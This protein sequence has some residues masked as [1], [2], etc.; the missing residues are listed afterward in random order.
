MVI[1]FPRKNLY[2]KKLR[3]DSLHRRLCTDNLRKGVKGN[4][5][6]LTRPP[7]PLY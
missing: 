1:L 6:H 7:R 3:I 4:P 5:E 2:Q